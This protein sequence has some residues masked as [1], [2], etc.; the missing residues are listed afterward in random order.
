MTKQCVVCGAGGGTGGGAGGAGV[1]G[2]I[3]AIFVAIVLP[4][5]IEIGFQNLRIH[6]V[7]VKSFGSTGCAVITPLGALTSKATQLQKLE[8]LWHLQKDIRALPG[9]GH[10]ETCEMDRMEMP[11]CSPCRLKLLVSSLPLHKRLRPC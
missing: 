2:H 5:D 11:R 1:G 4:L 10:L 8:K 9:P 3:K 6:A 7:A